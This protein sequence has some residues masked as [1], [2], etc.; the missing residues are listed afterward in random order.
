VQKFLAEVAEEFSR[1]TDECARLKAGFDRM[2]TELVQ[3]AVERDILQTRLKKLTTDVETARGQATTAHDKI[4]TYQ[5]QESV[6]AQVTAERDTSQG[7]VKELTAEI[8]TLRAA[9]QDYIAVWHE[10]K[11]LLAQVVA[12]RDSLEAK[13]IEATAELETLRKKAA[14]SEGRSQATGRR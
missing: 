7:R 1:L 9:A 3:V 10:Q 12:E 5:V 6:L 11:R 13:L 8:D 14:P 2:K 4:V